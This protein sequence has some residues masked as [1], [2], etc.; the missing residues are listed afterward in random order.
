MYLLLLASALLSLCAGDPYVPGNPGAAWTQD[1]ILITKAKFFYWF[2]WT[3]SAAKHLRLGFHDCIKYA[4]GTGGCDGC[5]NWKGMDV[6]LAIAAHARNLSVEDGGGN[7]GLG[8]TVRNLERFYLEANFPHGAP[9]LSESP[10]DLGWSRADLWAFSSVVA[11]EFAVMVNNL[12]CEEADVSQYGHSMA[13]CSHH[14]GDPGCKVNIERPFQFHTG[15]SDC[16]DDFLTKPPKKRST[17]VHR[18]PEERPLN[19]FEQSSLI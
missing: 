2:G 15:R 17:P 5:L 7:N 11:V 9:V 12:K 18:M 13:G 4:D 8:D 6:K 16:T 1:E 3:D 19:T 14:Q 10:K